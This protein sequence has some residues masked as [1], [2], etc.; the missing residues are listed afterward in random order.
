MSLTIE[1][2]NAGVSGNLLDLKRLSLNDYDVLLICDFL[3]ENPHITTLDLSFNN[4]GVTGAQLLARNQTI[5]SLDISF[6]QLEEEGAKVLATNQTI[7][8]LY[9]AQ[10]DL[11]ESGARY[12]ANNQTITSLNIAGNKIGAGVRYFADNKTITS[13][14]I[15]DNEIG[16]ADIQELTANKT[17]TIL[18]A[19]FNNIS[20]EGA[21]ALASN[22]TITSLVI[23]HNRIG[24]KGTRALACNEKITGLDIYGNNIGKSAIALVNNRTLTKLRLDIKKEIA[25]LFLDALINNTTLVEIDV[26]CEEEFIE[27]EF[28]DTVAK[29]CNRNKLKIP[30]IKNLQL[31]RLFFQAQRTWDQETN[32]KEEICYLGRLSGEMM[33]TIASHAIDNYN[34]IKYRFFADYADFRDKGNLALLKQQ[35][36]NSVDTEAIPYSQ[37]KRMYV[38]MET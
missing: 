28:L 32:D 11:G 38:V 5:K 31:A 35:L 13:L 3:K 33:E 6:N 24:S 17:I 34:A 4:I 26:R 18:N 29:I 23:A 22:Q 30:L 1:R 37:N 21:Q 25:Q 8:S 15:A 36:P 9:I 19:S 14:S 12:L 10:N 27:D 2:I 20:D 7:T 16:D